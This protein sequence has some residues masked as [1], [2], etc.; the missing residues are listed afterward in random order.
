MFSRVTAESREIA[1]LWFKK[2]TQCACAQRNHTDVFASQFHLGVI[3]SLK[4]PTWIRKEAFT[5]VSPTYSYDLLER[6]LYRF[7][8]ESKFRVSRVNDDF[9]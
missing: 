3:R 9:R 6:E 1:L 4:F 8:L 2:L 7:G 5:P